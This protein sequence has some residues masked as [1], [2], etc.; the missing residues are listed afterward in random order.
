[1][2]KKDFNEFLEK[3]FTSET[4]DYPMRREKYDE[5]ILKI[6]KVEMQ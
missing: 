6:K 4:Y 2:L 3:R 1:M 5:L